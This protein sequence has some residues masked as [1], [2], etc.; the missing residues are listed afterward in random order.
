MAIQTI[1]TGSSRHMIHQLWIGD[2]E[3]E[4]QIEG[5]KQI[6]RYHPAGYG[7]RVTAP[8]LCDEIAGVKHYA[9]KFFCNFSRG[10]SCD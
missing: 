1:D 3:E 5:E 6:A 4:L 7:T 2:S 8:K 10:T 9:G